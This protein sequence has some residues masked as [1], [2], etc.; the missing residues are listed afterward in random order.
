VTFR[1]AVTTHPCAG[2]T[3]RRR[4]F[5]MRGSRT[6]GS[7]RRKPRRAGNTMGS[8]KIDICGSGGAR[9]MPFEKPVLS[10]LLPSECKRDSESEN[11]AGHRIPRRALYAIQ[12]IWAP[13][14]AVGRQSRARSPPVLPEADAKSEGEGSKRWMA[15]PSD[16]RIPREQ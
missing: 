8:F 13:R 3:L 6:S 1:R 4:D 7:S 11:A 10:R 2:G 12:S 5:G 14:D 16:R 9:T 15:K